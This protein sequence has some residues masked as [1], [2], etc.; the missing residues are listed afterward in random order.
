MLGDGRQS[1]DVVVVGVTFVIFGEQA[2]ADPHAQLLQGQH[3]QV[4]VQHQ[5]FGLLAVGLDGRQL[6]VC[7]Y[8]LKA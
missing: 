4:G 8:L 1:V 7:H 2:G 5:V 3:T 6:T